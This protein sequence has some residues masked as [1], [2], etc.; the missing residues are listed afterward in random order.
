M[1]DFGQYTQ[2][3]VFSRL[4]ESCAHDG[5]TRPCVRCGKPTKACSILGAAICNRCLGASK[6]R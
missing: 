1:L 5:K 2:Q 4:K 6:S 3:E